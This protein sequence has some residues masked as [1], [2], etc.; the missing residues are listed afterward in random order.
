MSPSFDLKKSRILV[1]D[2]EPEI[3]A[4]VVS[5]FSQKGYEVAEASG[6]V[7]GI[8]LA[9]AGN[10]HAVLLDLNMPEMDG[11]TVLENLRK[12]NPDLQVIIMTGHGTLENA[13][14]AMKLGAADYVLKPVNLHELEARI[15]KAAEK[16][17]LHSLLG[18]YEAGKAVFSTVKQEELV[19]IVMDLIWKTLKVDQASLLL[20][21]E[22]GKLYIAAGRNL[23]R[24][25][26]QKT[27]LMIGEKV[28]SLP[29]D[30]QQNF[31]LA[32]NF[33]EHE[34]FKNF[35]GKTQIGSAIICP[36]FSRDRFLGVLNLDRM[37]GG[38]P[39]SGHDR[40]CAV[41]FASQVS[42]AVQNSGLYQAL[43]RKAAENEAMQKNLHQAEK[44]ASL[45]RFASGVA[46][47]I[48]N[49][50]TSVM[51]FAH[52]IIENKNSA[53]IGRY[54]EII[55][56]QA[57]R[58]GKIVQDLLV[59]SK[60]GKHKEA[61][62]EWL[63]MKGFIS[64]V[65][66]NM[67]ALLREK[68][69]KVEILWPDDELWVCGISSQLKILVENI[70]QNA[71]Q[72]MAERISGK[73]IVISAVFKIGKAVI[74]FRDN[75]CG[76]NPDIV[77]RIFDP[78]FTGKEIGKGAGLGLS[79]CHSIADGHGGNIKLNEE[80][81]DGA[82]FI[83]EFPA[84]RQM[85]T[86]PEFQFIHLS[87]RKSILVVEDESSIRDLF[88]HLL[89][90]RYEL[91]CVRD[92]EAALEI[93]KRQDFD[94]VICD[95]RMPKMN[96]IQLFESLRSLKPHLLRKFLF[97]SGSHKSS[98]GFDR[99]LETNNLQSLDKPFDKNVLLRKLESILQQEEKKAA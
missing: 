11:I 23:P 26:A 38:E 52:L 73:K 76:V 68:Q 4:I 47:E 59:F 6:G 96:G 93:L 61:G 70:I 71:E 5:F 1:I 46:H 82:E 80:I 41:I 50:L 65:L 58:C 57:K 19:E 60:S 51:G 75:G 49:P 67:T 86:A 78:F 81:K 8:N 56:D 63:E 44:L 88:A 20:T 90:S 83:V 92:G 62:K 7:Q 55:Y 10:F 3:R 2:N 37:K 24:E 35:K 79:L 74:R 13:V 14:Q 77:G 89:G 29:P 21:D 28:A 30:E 53:D 97:V 48:N 39:F 84:V 64:G 31:I 9:K 18:L 34:S 12:I 22:H 91:M 72:A 66:D 43:E 17:T 27:H 33:E 40:N 99:F 85:P 95:Y 36:L 94:A 32:E 54:A 16:T 87:N 98:D 42:M 45:G 69:I 25:S 15:Q